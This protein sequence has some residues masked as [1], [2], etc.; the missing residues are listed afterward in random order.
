MTKRCIKLMVLAVLVC[1]IFSVGAGGAAQAAKLVVNGNLRALSGDDLLL[2]NG[3]TLHLLGIKSPPRDQGKLAEISADALTQIVDQSV[4]DYDDSITDRYRRIVAQVYAVDASGKKIW[5][6]QEL[7]RQGMV[8]VYPPMG[9]E[10]RLNDMLAAEQEAYQQH[11][12]VWADRVYADIAAGQAQD[13]YGR[14]AFVVGKVV[15]AERIK[16]KLYL[17]FGDNWRTDFTVAIMARDLKNFRRV[18]VDPLDYANKTIRVRGWVKRD[19][20]PMIDVTD[21]HQIQIMPDVAA[22]KRR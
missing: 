14:Y 15:K 11:R 5:L 19:Y 4:L 3:R 10:P 13:V 8:I 9:N 1:G 22:P 21:P 20:G 7:L 2:P 12:G 6:Q 16:N 17:N 18:D